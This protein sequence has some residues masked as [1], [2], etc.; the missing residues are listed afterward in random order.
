[1]MNPHDED[2]PSARSDHD[3]GTD[4]DHAANSSGRIDRVLGEVA[5]PGASVSALA[6]RA[7]DGTVIAAVD[8][9][10]AVAPASTTKLLTGAL[11]LEWLG[12]AHRFETTIATSGTIEDNVLVGDLVLRGTGAPDLDA[13]DLAGMAADLGNR[14]DRVEGDLVCD[15]A[16]FVGP[17]RG[18]G[19]VW[20]DDHHAYGARSSALALC[21]NVVDVTVTVSDRGDTP[22][23]GISLSVDPRSDALSFVADVGIETEPGGSATDPAAGDDG[24]DLTARADCTGRIRVTG[25]VPPGTDRT[26]TIP[27][28]VPV[29]HCGHATLDALASAGVEVTG[30]CRIAE[31]G[32]VAD[33][34]LAAVESAPVRDLIGPMTVTSDNFV[35]DQLARAVSA[36]TAG[37]GSWDAWETTVRDH[38]DSLEVVAGRVCD[39]SGLSR[40][41]R[42]PARA[43][44]AHFDWADRQDW[45]DVFLGSL[46]EPGAGTLS[47]RLDGVPVIAKTGTLTGARALAGRV[48]HGTDAVYFGLLVGDIT[49]DEDAVTDRQDAFV[50]ALATTVGQD[51]FHRE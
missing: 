32:V 31:E 23:D 36:A 3:S 49:V 8:P 35:A 44:V 38:L 20:S 42:L 45:S 19:R 40:Y 41:N 10:R 5:P 50:R 29:E 1:M 12:P 48:A 47:D 37:E 13:D 24:S 17:Q 11:A 46:P 4:N 51:E 34:T 14:L 2:A 33:R 7:V 21:G 18:P 26:L 27:V 16:R 6:V 15:T 43:L 25:T 39:G 28:P 30:E 9:G 22:A